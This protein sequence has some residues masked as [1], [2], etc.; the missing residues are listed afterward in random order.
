M[1]IQAPL[2]LSDGL[3]KLPDSRY[4]IP[5]LSPS[6]PAEVACVENLHICQ[7]S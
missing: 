5:E 6:S 1:S 2:D 4:Q 7:I 3:E